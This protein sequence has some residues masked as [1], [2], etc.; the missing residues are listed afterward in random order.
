MATEDKVVALADVVL[1]VTTITAEDAQAV[2]LAKEGYDATWTV[3]DSEPAAHADKKPAK[4]KVVEW[5]FSAALQPFAFAGTC[6][7]VKPSKAS[8]EYFAG[9]IRIGHWY[10]VAPKISSLKQLSNFEP[11][12][13][14]A[15][16]IGFQKRLMDVRASE[17]YEKELAVFTDCGRGVCRTNNARITPQYAA[18][19]EADS[20]RAFWGN[21]A[22]TQCGNLADVFPHETAVSWIRREL[23]RTTPTKAWQETR[24]EYGKLLREVCAALSASNNVEALCR[25]F[26]KRLADL[27]GRHG[28]RLMH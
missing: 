2:Q 18:A 12:K 21:D 15:V 11:C 24:L 3:P 26:A 22:A 4:E 28:D 6:H 16:N 19:L 23:V 8:G 14:Y 13:A 9:D 17:R 27:L 25:C 10:V 5:Y 7:H 1:A 20:L